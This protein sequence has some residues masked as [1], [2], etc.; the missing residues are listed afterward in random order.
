MATES[1]APPEARGYVQP[2]IDVPALAGLLDG[3]YADVRDLVRTNLVDL[4]L[5]P[6]RGRDPEPRRLPRAGQRARGRDG[7]DRP[8]RHGLPEGVRRRRRHRRLAGGLRDARL[9]RPVG[10]GEGRRAVR[11]VRRRDP[12]A[13]HQ[14]PPRRLPRR[15]HHR[16]AHGLLR[17][18]RDRARVQRAG[19]SAPSRRTTPTTEEFVLD[20]PDDAVAQGLHRQRRRST[21]S[22]RWSS[23]SSRWPASGRGRARPRRADPRR[24]ARCSAGVRIEDAAPRWA[25]TASTTA[26][27][28]STASG[29][30]RTALL[31]RFADVR[32]TGVYSSPIDNPNR[33]FFTM[34]GTLVQGRVCVGGAGINAAKVAM[35]HRDPLRPARGASSRRRPAARRTCS[36]TTGST[37][38]GC[39]RCWRGPTRCT[40]PRRS[41]PASATTS[42]AGCDRR[43]ARPARARVA[44]GRHQGAR[45][46][47]RDPDD[48]GVPRGLW[49]RGLPLGQPVRRAQG[50]HRRLHD[51][52]GRQHVLLQLV[53]KGLLT[54]Y[55][56]DFEDL[57]QL[58]MVRFV[59]VLAV[60]TVI[61]KTNAHKLLSGCATCCRAATSGTRRPGSSTPTTSSRCCGSARST[62]W[63]ASR[64]GSSAASTTR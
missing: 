59:T 14:A 40:S 53:A 3:K 27:S 45:H 51:V 47:A 44:G 10:P 63:P 9:R 31:N 41:W 13:R 54:D 11:P 30:P 22:W 26:G 16:R 64:G 24:T 58:G 20:T 50:R 37:S 5:R 35:T 33:R 12:P 6:R 60:E 61:E 36:S 48:P 7:G 2:E 32:R 38:G 1:A 8:D 15:P 62:C 39:S 56:S 19:G 42:S 21:P 4:R 57:D 23:P 18:D 25:S 28:G 17:D 55:A 34:L 46:L 52:R 49:R 29:C 43:R